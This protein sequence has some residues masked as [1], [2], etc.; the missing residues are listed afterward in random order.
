MTSEHILII[1][2]LLII[3]Y[4]VYEPSF[5]TRFQDGSAGGGYLS[6]YVKKM[7][8][9]GHPLI[10]SV[11]DSGADLRILGQRFSSTDQGVERM[12]R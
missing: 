9:V 2:L 4:K 10:N 11:D 7:G 3:L 12:R 5:G 8:Y 1:V 6:G